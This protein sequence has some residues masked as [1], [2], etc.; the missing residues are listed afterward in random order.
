MKINEKKIPIRAN[1]PRSVIFLW[2]KANFLLSSL[3]NSYQCY[4]ANI[5][6]TTVMTQE[7][8]Q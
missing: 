6:A 4:T 1:T 7:V 8:Q 3:S 5:R 2:V